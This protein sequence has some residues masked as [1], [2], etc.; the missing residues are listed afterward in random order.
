M[1]RTRAP[2]DDD[3]TRVAVCGRRPRAHM[4]LVDSFELNYTSRIQSNLRFT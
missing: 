4:H 1:T 2:L 3:A